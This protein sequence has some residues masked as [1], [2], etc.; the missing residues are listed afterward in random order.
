MMVRWHDD[1]MGE[2]GTPSPVRSSQPECSSLWE[3]VQEQSHHVPATTATTATPLPF[4]SAFISTA[5]LAIW[6]LTSK[7]LAT[8]ALVVVVVGH[9]RIGLEWGH[10]WKL[11]EG[12]I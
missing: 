1:T 7:A 12:V 2:D 4:L 11:L 10:R 3:V 5:A 6:P 9:P 8:S